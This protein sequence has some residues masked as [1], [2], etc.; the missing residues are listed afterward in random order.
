MNIQEN[1]TP[2]YHMTL[3]QNVFVAK[4]N[5]VDYIWKSANLEGIAVTYSDTQVIYDGMSVSE[6][7][8]DEINAVNDLKHAWHFLLDTIKEPVTFDF[9]RMLHRQLGKF[10]VINAGS[11]R[12]D[13]VHIGGTE[14]IPE[15]PDEKK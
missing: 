3:E 8:I 15:Y 2:K 1:F 7:T 4:R 10:T 11:L 9:M 12:I 6:Y 14:W 13:D 5:I